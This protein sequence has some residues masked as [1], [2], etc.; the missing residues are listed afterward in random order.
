MHH[1]DEWG[2]TA[3]SD[4]TAASGP[5]VLLEACSVT[6]SYRRRRGRG[7]ATGASQVVGAARA[8]GGSFSSI[9]ALEHVSLEVARGEVLGI[10]GSS[11]SGKSTLARLLLALEEPDEGEVRCFGERVDHRPERE[12]TALRRQV[13]IVFQ[14]PMG[15]L[16]PRMRIGTSIAEPLRSLRIEGDHRVRVAELLERVGLSPGAMRRYPRELSGGERQRI[17]I[18]RALAPRPSVLV[19]DEPVSALDVSVRAQVLNL[20]SELIRDF[21]LTVVFISHDMGVVRHLC[22]RVAVL[23]QGRLVEQGTTADIFSAPRHSATKALL[24]AVP[25][26]GPAAPWPAGA[27]PAGLPPPAPSAEG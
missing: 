9:L 22:D 17:A 4:T 6:K 19:A 15:S 10:V 25:R 12:L 26:I 13:Q 21:S 16:D 7:P 2:G 5:A 1:R 18:A 24:A 11:G 8:P 3:V 14:D 23:D 27:Q 20:L